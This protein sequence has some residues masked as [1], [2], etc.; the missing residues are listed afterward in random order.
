MEEIRIYQT[1]WRRELFIAILCLAITFFTPFM[2]RYKPGELGLMLFFGIT[3]LFILFMGFRDR[4]LHRP[5]LTITDESIIER[6]NHYP[7]IVIHFDKVKSFER[8]TLRFMGHTSYTG[9]II[10]HLKNGNGFVNIISA[11]NLTMKSQQLYDLLNERLENHK[12]T[13]RRRT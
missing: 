13:Q 3:G 4:L 6:R 2:G 12:E 7:E 1:I 8:E 10:V 5:Y 11:N 9:M